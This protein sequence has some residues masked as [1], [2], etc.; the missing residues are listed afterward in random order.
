M[1]RNLI[2]YRIL[3]RIPKLAHSLMLRNIIASFH[4]CFKFK[5]RSEKIF[6]LNS[7]VSDEN[8]PLSKS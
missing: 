3:Y 1:L 8:F 7:M 2:A 5:H 6:L 4:Q